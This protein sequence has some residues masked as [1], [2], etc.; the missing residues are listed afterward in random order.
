MSITKLLPLILAVIAG[1]A[2]ALLFSSK[3]TT[4]APEIKPG[5]LK[6]QSEDIEQ[7]YAVIADSFTR[8]SQRAAGQLMHAK[9]ELILLQQKNNRLQSEVL[10]LA[11]KETP[12]TRADTIRNLRNCDSLRT[13]TISLMK[14]EEEKDSLCAELA[15]YFAETL[16]LKDSVSKA[17]RDKY[18]ALKQTFTR[19]VEQLENAAVNLKALHKQEKHR[20]LKSKI[21][22]FAIAAGSGIAAGLML[23]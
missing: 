21:V 17:D 9:K 19:T 22:A 1:I 13:L 14:Q 6:K 11:R 12:V 23:K 4:P 7:R 2:I 18:A 8:L 16:A 15:D 5:E 3:P 10:A 20:K